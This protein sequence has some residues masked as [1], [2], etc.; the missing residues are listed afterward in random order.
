MNVKRMKRQ[1]TEREKISAKDMSDEEL[2]SKTH[3]KL[4]RVNNKKTTQ[5][6]K[7][8]NRHLTKDAWIANKHMKSSKTYVIR[9]T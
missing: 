7:D 3:R 2:L 9:E 1:A 5:W 4:F 8:L 6:A